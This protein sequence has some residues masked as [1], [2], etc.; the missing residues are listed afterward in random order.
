MKEEVKQI[1]IS[2]TKEVWK[3]LKVISIQ[4]E[5]SLNQVAQEILERYLSRKGKADITNIVNE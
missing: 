4:K 5:I 3:N 2:I 1:N